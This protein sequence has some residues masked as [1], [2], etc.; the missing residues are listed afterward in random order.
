MGAQSAAAAAATRGGAAARNR[1]FAIA[2]TVAVALY[3][4][5]TA[6]RMFDL[7]SFTTANQRQPCHDGASAATVQN[8]GRLVP[9]EAHVMSKCPDT[10]VCTEFTS[11]SVYA[12]LRASRTAG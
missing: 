6:T 8:P 2:L 11:R 12:P 10:K 7:S 1:P 4:V 9:L 3:F 5:F